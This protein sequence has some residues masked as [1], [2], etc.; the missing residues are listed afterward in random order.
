M[1]LINWYKRKPFA[2]SIWYRPAKNTT[3]L[4][5]H[6][7]FLSMLIKYKCMHCSHHYY[8][9]FSFNGCGVFDLW[10]L[11]A[12]L[13]HHASLQKKTRQNAFILFMFHEQDVSEK[14]G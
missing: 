11:N 4:Y 10:K 7:P 14:V 6:N 3:V 8:T 5:K 9:Y 12:T 2:D 1:T 13:M